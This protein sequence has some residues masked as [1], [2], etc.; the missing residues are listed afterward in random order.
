MK[1]IRALVLFDLQTRNFRVV[2]CSRSSLCRTYISKECPPYCPAIVAVKDFVYKRRV[3]KG[4][5]K[6]I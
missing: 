1:K 6:Q 3:P 2:D 5:V 4:D